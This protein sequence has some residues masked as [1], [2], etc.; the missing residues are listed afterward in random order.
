MTLSIVQKS[1]R[2]LVA[3]GILFLMAVLAMGFLSYRLSDVDYWTIH[4][5][6]VIEELKDSLSSL[7]DVETGQRGYL[8]THKQEFLEPYNSGIASTFTHIDEIKRLTVD[9]PTQQQNV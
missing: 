3:T 9:N 4:T 8:L 5:H 6:K 2:A 1:I 7:Q